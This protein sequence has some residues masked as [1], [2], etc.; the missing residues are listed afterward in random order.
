MLTAKSANDIE[1]E[2]AQALARTLFGLMPVNEGKY[3]PLTRMD[4]AM[5]L[6]IAYLRAH[7]SYDDGNDM[8]AQAILEYAMGLDSEHGEGWLIDSDKQW[9]E[10]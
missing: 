9:I 6:S 3:T 7:T 10:A 1:S 2:I 8:R 4:K 5:A